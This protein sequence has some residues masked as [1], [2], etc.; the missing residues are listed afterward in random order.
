[1]SEPTQTEPALSLERLAKPATVMADVI[2]A[3]RESG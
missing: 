3:T 1:M 2:E